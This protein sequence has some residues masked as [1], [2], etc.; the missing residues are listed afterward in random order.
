MGQFSYFTQ[1]TGRR[2]VIDNH[3]EVT[4]I[5]DKGNRWVQE[6][7]TYEGYGEF[8]GMDFYELL[9]QMNGKINRDEGIEIAFSGKHHK[10]PNI[11]LLPDSWLYSVKGPDS[12]P[13]QG[14]G[15]YDE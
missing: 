15:D 11:I 2:I 14:F 8:G 9:A 12:D 5:D 10:S 3:P 6:A 7:N 4:M 1:D 13:D